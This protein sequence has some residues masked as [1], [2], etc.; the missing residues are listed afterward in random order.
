M[1]IRLPAPVDRGDWLRGD[2]AAPVIQVGHV[3][4]ECRVSRA[5]APLLAS[6]LARHPDYVAL[7]YR[8]LPLTDIDPD[9]LRAPCAAEAAGQLGRCW[10][11]HNAL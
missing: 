5:A 3:D 6:M 10:E 1:S 2:R 7:V 8:R 4:F 11:M 9:A